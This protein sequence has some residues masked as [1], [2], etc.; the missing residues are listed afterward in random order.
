MM[1]GTKYL[2]GH[3]AET[4]GWR[5][6]VPIALQKK[7]KKLKRMEGRQSIYRQEN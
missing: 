4:K 2:N 1:K 6:E 5:V 3:G 7:K